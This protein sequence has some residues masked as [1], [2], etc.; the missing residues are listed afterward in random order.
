MTSTLPVPEHIAH[1]IKPY[2][3][4]AATRLGAGT[5]QPALYAGYRRAGLTEQ[6]AGWLMALAIQKHLNPTAQYAQAS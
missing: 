6:E 1:V 3:P 4:D 2:V 5:S